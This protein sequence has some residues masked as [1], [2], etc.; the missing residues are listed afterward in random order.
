M[1]INRLQ[2]CIAIE[3]ERVWAKSEYWAV[4]FMATVELQMTVSMVGMV[5]RIPICEFGEERSWVF[6]EWMEEDA[7]N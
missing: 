5:N 7:I 3:R 1:T 6:G 2:S 4:E